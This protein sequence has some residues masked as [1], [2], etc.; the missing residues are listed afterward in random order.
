MIISSWLFECATTQRIVPVDAHLI[1]LRDPDLRPPNNPT[2][3][4]TELLRP[5]LSSAG[6]IG[7][8]TM[9][10]ETMETSK[11]N[12]LSPS[13]GTV[14]NPISKLDQL[15][16]NSASSDSESSFTDQHQETSDPS[17]AVRQLQQHLDELR[18]A[19]QEQQL[20]R[21][22]RRLREKDSDHHPHPPIRIKG[23]GRRARQREGVREKHLLDSQVS[24]SQLMQV[25]YDDPE[26]RREKERVLARIKRC[27]L[28]NRG[29]V[30]IRIGVGV[31]FYCYPSRPRGV[32]LC[33]LGKK[34]SLLKGLTQK[35]IF[36]KPPELKGILRPPELGG[37]SSS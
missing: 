7:E 11:S 20:R 14:Q 28:G 27:D 26:G 10:T 25:T 9:E 23:R 24:D 31:W 34:I 3:G 17:E 6:A 19:P 21:Q 33:D 18:E 13:K 22:S 4:G 1:A 8:E 36:P 37:T 32:L 15:S 16:P 30:R 5:A 12:E 2:S 29:V 35:M